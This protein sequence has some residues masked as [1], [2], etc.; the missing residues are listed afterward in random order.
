MLISA[1]VLPSTRATIFEYVL[2]PVALNPLPICQFAKQEMNAAVNIKPII[3]YRP[4]FFPISG[5][6]KK[7]TPIIE[8]H[9]VKRELL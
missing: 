6:V 8:L 2:P 9:S 4:L 1:E 5:R 7:P 3:G